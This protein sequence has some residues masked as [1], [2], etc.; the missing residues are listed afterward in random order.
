MSKN[1]ADGVVATAP[2]PAT[3]GLTLNVQTGQAARYYLGKAIIA[4]SGVR[5]SITNS[6]VVLITAINTGTDQLT[7]TRIQESSNARTVIVGDLIYQGLTAAMMDGMATTLVSGEIPGGLVN[8]SNT[9]FTTSSPLATGSLKVFR[10]GIRLKA[11]GADFTEG[12]QGFTMVTA[13]TTGA[14]LLVDYNVQNTTFV[15]GTNS[16]LTD[17]TPSGSVN[18]SNTSFSAARAYIAGSLEVYLGGIK[19]RR[20]TDFTETTPTSGVFTMTTAPTTGQSIRINY[21]FN[22]NPS[23]NADTV[24]GIHASTSPIAN[25]LLALNTRAQSGEWWEEVGRVT[26]GATAALMTA[27]ITPKKYLYI[28]FYCKATGGAIAPWL[29]FNGDTGTNY[30]FKYAVGYSTPATLASQVG[31]T[32]N[33]NSPT[34]YIQGDAHILNIQTEEKLVQGM[35]HTM[36]TAGAANLPET[37][38]YLGKWVNTVNQISSITVFDASANVRLAAGSELVVLGHD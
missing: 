37:I 28:L 15:V 18:S 12:A 26:L 35:A 27:T 32:L 10:N 21:L 2:S 16:T 33:P 5:P 36:A 7:I 23:S 30:P 14:V 24:D 38:D 29:R 34:T 17:E 11:G 22:L 19:Q 25:Q 9:V 3:T 20:G 31:I 8:S 6:E 4:P 1:F 13:P